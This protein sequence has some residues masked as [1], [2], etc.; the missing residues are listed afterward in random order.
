MRYLTAAM[1]VVT[2]SAWGGTFDNADTRVQAY[3]IERLAAELDTSE[4]LLVQ[5]RQDEWARAEYDGV[6]T[7]QLRVMGFSVLRCAEAL[8]G[9]GALKPGEAIYMYLPD[10]KK[11]AETRSG[12]GE[13]RPPY[14]PRLLADDEVL[15]MLASPLEEPDKERW[16]SS[17]RDPSLKGF[18]SDA[19]SMSAKD[20]CA[21]HGLERGLEGRMYT[22]KE[23][24]ALA[25]AYPAP[26]LPVTEMMRLNKGLLDGQRANRAKLS[27][28][29]GLVEL[30]KL[31]M[32]ELVYLA[33]T[34]DGD[35]GLAQYKALRARL[36]E[37]KEL[38]HPLELKTAFG[39]A[40]A[41]ALEGRRQRGHPS[42]SDSVEKPPDLG[43]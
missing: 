42:K 13:K 33:Y 23:G 5:Q 3:I 36:P 9:G 10:P 4:I 15:M 43:R 24:C 11:W 20:L 32:A 29:S 41:A 6:T 34:M 7:G 30:S 26:E 35:E 31:E 37:Y 18:V 8:K 40:L 2:A 12:R 38:S 27:G 22:L 14:L 21:T 28:T 25:V 16:A 39:K 1:M 17:D 19:K